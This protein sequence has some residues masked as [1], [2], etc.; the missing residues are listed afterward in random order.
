MA[1]TK[2]RKVSKSIVKS[3]PAPASASRQTSKRGAK[4]QI[5]K[6][7]VRRVPG[8]ARSG[9]GGG[10][11]GF[12]L[13]G[14]SLSTVGKVAKF[15][16]VGAGGFW[17]AGK[18]S[19]FI[20]PP[21]RAKYDTVEKYERAMSVWKWSLVGV[22]AATSIALGV[23]LSFISAPLAVFAAA[24]AMIPVI[25]DVFTIVRDMVKQRAQGGG[26]TK[27][28]RQFGAPSGVQGIDPNE[29]AV[30]VAGIDP[31]EIAI[32]VE[33]FDGDDDDE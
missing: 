6:S 16:A 3:A 18:I 28:A 13:K 27:V 11:S 19:A 23:G 4:R 33:G 8:T 9:G 12:T 29:I 17:L 10:A 1:K 24:G 31:N 15:G 14:L 30:G 25:F 22:K 20:K 5:V 7:A 26:S 32:G 21:E 2:R